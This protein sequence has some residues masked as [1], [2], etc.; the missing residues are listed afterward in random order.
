M[1]KE[2]KFSWAKRGRRENLKNALRNSRN[3]GE[4]LE[5]LRHFNF[6]PYKYSKE[7]YIYI[8]IYI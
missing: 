2:W 8:F 3:Y 1:D 6:R 4:M 7:R 5:K